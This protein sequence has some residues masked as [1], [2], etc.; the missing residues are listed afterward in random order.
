MP[1]SRC[2]FGAKRVGFI[3]TIHVAGS[4]GTAA[5]TW[6]DGC[7]TRMH[8]RSSAGRQSDGTSRRSGDTASRAIQRADHVSVRLCCTGPMTAARFDERP[9]SRSKGAEAIVDPLLLAR[10]PAWLQKTSRWSTERFQQPVN[11]LQSD[12]FAIGLRK[13]AGNDFSVHRQKIREGEA[14]CEWRPPAAPR[15]LWWGWSSRRAMVGAAYDSGGF[16]AH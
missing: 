11:V 3:P 8:A 1:A 2:P 16:Y 12:K 15:L 7:R 5:T 4:T 14:T 13:R 6:V 10:G 9:L